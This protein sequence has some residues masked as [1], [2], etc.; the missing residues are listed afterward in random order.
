MPP[1]LEQI[2]VVSVKGAKLFILV[3]KSNQ[4]TPHKALYW[5]LSDEWCCHP[6]VMKQMNV[7]HVRH[8]QLDIITIITDTISLSYQVVRTDY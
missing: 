8:I 2:T 5:G 6:A 7:F 1:P 3:V 4:R